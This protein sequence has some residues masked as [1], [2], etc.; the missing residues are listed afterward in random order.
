MREGSGGGAERRCCRDGVVKGRGKML[1]VEYKVLGLKKGL[2][3][4]LLYRFL[5]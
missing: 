5:F 4:D 2:P 1:G 3:E